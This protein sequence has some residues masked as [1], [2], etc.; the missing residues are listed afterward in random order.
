MWGSL[1]NLKGELSEIGQAL[2][3]NI[4]KSDPKKDKHLYTLIARNICRD[5]PKAG[6]MQLL[7]AFVEKYKNTKKG[8]P[9]DLFEWICKKIHN[10]PLLLQNAIKDLL[11]LLLEITKN[12]STQHEIRRIIGATEPSADTVL[13]QIRDA[14]EKQLQNPQLWKSAL[15]SFEEDSSFFSDTD[16]DI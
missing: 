10:K 7:K 11:P 3:K 15:E 8:L 13:K 6:N 9:L 2:L 14:V 16:S 12:A 4:A 1:S 5:L